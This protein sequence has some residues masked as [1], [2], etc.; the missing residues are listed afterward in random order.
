M[1]FDSF[2]PLV[3][4][5]I[6]GL[7]TVWLM[8]RWSAAVPLAFKGKGAEQL[9]SEYKTG[10]VA[11]NAL[12]FATIALGIY[13]LNVWHVPRNSWAHGLLVIGLAVVAAAAGLLLPTVG[14]RRAYVAEAIAAFAIAERTPLV[15]LAGI[16]VIGAICLASA[17]SMLAW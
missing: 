2:R 6:G 14:K 5:L 4:G 11:A 9:V 15:V 12:F 10:I 3:S 13:L 16:G 8:K 17:L 7:L 1:E